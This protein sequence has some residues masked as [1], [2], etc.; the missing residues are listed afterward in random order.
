[1]SRGTRGSAAVLATTLA[2]LLVVV[3]LL[4]TVVGGAIADQRRAESAADLAALAGATAVQAGR[5]ACVAAAQVARR[6]GAVLVRCVADGEVV[7]LSVRRPTR[8]GLLGLVGRLG[9]GLA[10]T[11]EARAG[12]VPERS[13]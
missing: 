6:N 12:P 11:A 2:G 5:D 3:A 13:A 10:V 8:I 7:T 9:H 1:M 4:A